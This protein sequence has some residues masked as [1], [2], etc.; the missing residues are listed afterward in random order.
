[1]KPH[2]KET[3]ILYELKNVPRK[4]NYKFICIKA[5]NSNKNCVNENSENRP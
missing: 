1:M 3:R 2:L 4:E 5:V